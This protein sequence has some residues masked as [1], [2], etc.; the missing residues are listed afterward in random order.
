M[1]STIDADTYKKL[2]EPYRNNLYV[3]QQ[4]E[5]LTSPENFKPILKNDKYVYSKVFTENNERCT[6]IQAGLG[7]GKTQG[8]LD[9]IN[10]HHYDSIVFLSPR[11]SFAKS[12]HARLTEETEYE[13]AVYNK[14]KKSYIISEPYIVIQTESLHRLNLNAYTNWGNNTLLIVD[15]CE[16]IAPQMTVGKTH[17]INHMKN[18]DTFANLFMQCSKIICLDAF[19]SPKTVNPLQDLQVD[20]NLYKYTVPLAK[21]VCRPL[22]TLEFL[23]QKL[24]EDLINGKRIYLQCT[25]NK[26]LNEVMLPRVKAIC[27]K[28]E[29]DIKI[30]EHHSKRNTVKLVDIKNEWPKFDLV[31]CTST[32]T[33]GVNFDTVG[34]FDSLYC[35][36]SSSSRNLTRDVFQGLYRVRHVKDNTLTYF[37]DPR[38]IGVSMLSS[39]KFVKM[40]MLYSTQLKNQQATHHL[41]EKYEQT[42]RWI[43]NLIISNRYEQSMS[44][45]NLVPMFQ[46]YLK[47]CCYTEEEVSCDREARYLDPDDIECKHDIEYSDIPEIDLEQLKALKTK[48]IEGI[49]LTDVEHASI[50]KFWMIN[51][52]VPNRDTDQR[53][54][55][56]NMCWNYFKDYGYSK[57]S[58]VGYEKGVVDGSIR[59]RDLLEQ[60]KFSSVVDKLS[61]RLEMMSDI[62]QQLGLK[63]SYELGAQ[64]SKEQI[65]LSAQWFIHN[66]KKIHNIFDIRIQVD[67]SKK[68]LPP[69]RISTS[70]I[71][72]VF[73]KWGYSKFKKC[74]KKVRSKSIKG[75]KQQDI[76]PFEISSQNEKYERVGNE[77]LLNRQHP[78][79]FIKARVKTKYD[80]LLTSSKKIKADLELVEK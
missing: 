32:I 49:D 54:E 63:T 69:P 38:L 34:V 33:V 51:C 74:A 12:V 36:A 73:G 39:K 79:D 1:K 75:S 6:V 45:I 31:V 4:I 30:C 67:K 23:I 70:L 48:K 15:E 7:K 71:N 27:L 14:S 64:V 37:L 47:E 41:N 3:Q 66:Y 44:C 21:R 28:N 24:A 22:K 20:F 72:K 55:D 62:C 2:T 5:L 10:S 13:F 11:V 35:Y 9:H 56:Y 52:L 29:K 18:L 59:I 58:N 61:L 26:R 78:S 76:T 46:H 42:P 57:F 80:R 8:T 19:V 60:T 77:M 65:E 17:A 53:E 68:P 16:S 43:Q 40:D 25:S 50:S